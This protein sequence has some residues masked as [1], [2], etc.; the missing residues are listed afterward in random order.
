[1]NFRISLP[2]RSKE[3]QPSFEFSHPVCVRTIDFFGRNFQKHTFVNTLLLPDYCI[4]RRIHV[5]NANVSRRSG[6]ID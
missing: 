4:L 1:M 2:F 3:R 5:P 6:S